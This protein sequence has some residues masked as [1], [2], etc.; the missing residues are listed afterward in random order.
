[1]IQTKQDVGIITE[2]KKDAVCT[3]KSAICIKVN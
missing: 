1:V 2:V 3:T